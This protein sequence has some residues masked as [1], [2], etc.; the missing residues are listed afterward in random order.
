VRE[1]L[2]PEHALVANPS[3]VYAVAMKKLE[4]VMLPILKSFRRIGQG[5]LVR[6]QISNILQFGCELDAHMLFQSL[7]TFNRS[8]MNEVR[9]HYR[10]PDSNPYP[11]KDNPLMY[12]LSLL[13]EACGM[14]DPLHKIYI[15]SQPLE[16][17]PVVLLLFLLTYLPKVRVMIIISIIII[18]TN[19][20]D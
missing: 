3:K 10:D 18:E 17:L 7:D 11:S 16:G 13:T 8:T 9:Q 12:E 20:T 5:Q 14:D 6:R 1:S 15:T 2:F 19:S 4:N